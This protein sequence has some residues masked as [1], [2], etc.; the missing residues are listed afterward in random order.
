MTSAAKVTLNRGQTAGLLVVATAGGDYSGQVSLAVTGLP[1][2]V[3]ARWSSTSFPASGAG[4]SV[5]S[6][7]LTASENAPLTQDSLKITA[8]GDGLEAQSLWNLEVSQGVNFGFLP[9][10]P[11]PMQP[12][13]IDRTPQVPFP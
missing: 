13:P 5:A 9:D 12:K 8:S 11:E 6:L 3:S 10:R 1:T 2:G 4:V 7:M